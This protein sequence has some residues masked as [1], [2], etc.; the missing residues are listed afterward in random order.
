MRNRPIMGSAGTYRKTMLL[1]RFDLDL[2]LIDN[3]IND[4]DCEIWEIQSKRDAQQQ[5]FFDIFP[6]Q[7]PGIIPAFDMNF[8]HTHASKC[9]DRPAYSPGAGS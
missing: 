7:R 8:C 9:G 1:L 4:P 6:H 3:N 2:K 5:G